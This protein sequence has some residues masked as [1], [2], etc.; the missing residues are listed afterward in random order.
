M[1]HQIDFSC[2]GCADRWNEHWAYGNFTWRLVY[3]T[4]PYFL[5]RAPLAE[6]INEMIRTGIKIHKCVRIREA[7]GI[8]RRDVS[9][10]YIKMSEKDLHT[11]GVY[12]LGIK[13]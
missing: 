13:R 3:G 10:K 2:H 1:S 7:G 6:H 8:S 12:V 4:R 9:R 11:H 5:N